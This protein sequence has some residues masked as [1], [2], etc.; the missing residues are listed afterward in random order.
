MA[1]VGVG[2]GRD[3][4]GDLHLEVGMDEGEQLGQV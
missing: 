2:L 4:R 1:A 3:V